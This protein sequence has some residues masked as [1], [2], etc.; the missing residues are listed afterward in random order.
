MPAPRSYSNASMFISFCL[1]AACTDMIPFVLERSWWLTGKR[2]QCQ[3]NLTLRPVWYSRNLSHVSLSFY[4]E[5]TVTRPNGYWNGV[6]RPG[7]S[8]SRSA[9]PNN[10]KASEIGCPDERVDTII[11][12]IDH[13]VLCF[14]GPNGNNH[15][16]IQDPVDFIS[17]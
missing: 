8:H 13:K 10:A 3:A 11:N 16:A 2:L 9:R 6:G 1:Q 12:Y 7:T 15:G 5:L 4:V 14:I 17:V